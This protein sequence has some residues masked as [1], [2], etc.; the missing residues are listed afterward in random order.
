LTRALGLI[1]LLVLGFG[2]LY[3]AGTL[4]RQQQQA[5]LIQEARRETSEA[6][7][8]TAARI[9]P[10][11]GGSTLLLSANVAAIGET[12]IYARAEGYI[13]T[14]KV[15]IGDYV[16][17]DQL[18]V[19][20]DTPEL[21]QQLQTAKARLAQIQSNLAQ[22]KAALVQAEAQRKLAELNLGRARQLVAEG[23][24]P[25]QEGD[26]RQA[27]FDVRS[28]DTLA[29]RANITASEEAVKAQQ[30][31]VARLTELQQFKQ[32]RAPWEGIITQRNCAVGNLITPAALAAGRDLFRL[33]DVRRLRIF[34]NVPQANARDISVGQPVTVTIPDQNR[35]FQGRVSRTSN[36][37]ENQTRT[38]LT[39]VDVANDGRTLLPG[40]YVQA[41]FP[42]N[43]SRGALVVPGEAIVSRSDGSWCAFI[44]PGNKVQ[45]RKVTT[46]RDYGPKVEILS[47]AKDGDSVVLSPSDEIRDGLLVKPAFPKR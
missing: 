17:K 44:L 7:A 32:V 39:E 24:A 15:D 5:S 6:E 41:S 3:M 34:A 45:F 33:S 47:G 18:L 16:Q 23:V 30:A 28:A 22:S 46:G 19:E 12:P 2:G 1:L 8:V 11:S 25:R 27:Q 26:E 31:E 43:S 14:R 21:D 13:R 9:E 36:A 42:L 10:A 40:M 4:P 20:I 29:A 38:L 37:F 35:T